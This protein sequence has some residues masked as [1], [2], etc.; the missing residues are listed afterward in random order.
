VRGHFIVDV[1]ENLLPVR[2]QLL[3]STGKASHHLPFTVF[4]P[5]FLLNDEV[6]KL[7][8]KGDLCLILVTWASP[9]HPFESM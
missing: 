9:H 2:L 5:F 1:G 8:N 6:L 3:F 4:F 7:N